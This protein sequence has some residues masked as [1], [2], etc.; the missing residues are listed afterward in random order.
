MTFAFLVDSVPFTR[1]VRDGETSL[2]GSESA[3]LGLARALQARGHQVHLFATQLAQ[4]AVGLDAAGCTW[5]PI[6]SFQPM[7][8]FIEWDVVVALRWFGIFGLSPIQARLRL[9]WNQDLLVPG[10]MHHGVMAVAWALDRLVY[11]SDYQRA[12]WEDLEPALTSHGWVTKNG[13]DPHDLPASSTKDPNRII[14]IS[15]P[16]RGL[17]P[18][19]QL[20][21]KLREQHPDATLQICRYSSM[22]DSGGWGQVCRAYDEA[23]QAVNAEVGGIDYLG[24]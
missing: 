14:H 12:Q 5:H 10:A 24:E 23:V 22:Y 17:R 15:R 20:W 16:E 7:N 3:C 13:F 8:Q 18:L 21:P 6:E 9:L 19:L 4:E 1:A 2:G 11:V